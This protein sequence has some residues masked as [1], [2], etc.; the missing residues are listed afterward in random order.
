[1][2][3]GQISVSNVGLEVYPDPPGCCR[4]Y[5][6]KTLLLVRFTTCIPAE[7]LT[8]SA[9]GTELEGREGSPGLQQP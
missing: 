6:Y 8:A 9:S 2:D 4:Q 1:M 3:S 5:T 7:L